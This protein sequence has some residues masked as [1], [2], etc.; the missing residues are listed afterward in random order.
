MIQLNHVTREELFS[1]PPGIVIR[2]GVIP[3]TYIGDQRYYLVGLFP[4]LV[5]TDM[6]GG[7]KTGR[8]ERPI[9]CLIREIEEETDPV[10][11]RK[12]IKSLLDPDA[13]I[14]VWRQTAP[15]F[16]DY[17]YPFRQIR[18]GPVHRYYVLLKIDDPELEL[19]GA[20]HKEEVVSYEW[21][22]ETVLHQTSPT[23]FNDSCK[24]FLI[25]RDLCSLKKEVS[26]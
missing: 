20:T 10:T 26:A 21:I 6:G 1:P 16:R 2:A 22:P 12:V 14:E 17:N 9:D 3:Y 19:G 23:S 13:E 5:Y 18:P 15:T 8:R 7:C 25:S 24:D 11:A 4:D